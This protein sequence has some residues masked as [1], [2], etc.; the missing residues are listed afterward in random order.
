MTSNNEDSSWGGILAFFIVLLIL[1]AI[2]SNPSPPQPNTPSNP[3]T[4]Q[5]FAQSPSS[6]DI[7]AQLANSQNLLRA[8][9]NDVSRLEAQN[10]NIQEALD[11]VNNQL[12]LAQQQAREESK[13][14]SRE[15]WI[16]T[17]VGSL[18]GWLLGLIA[19]TR[20]ILTRLWNFIKR[21]FTSKSNREQEKNE[22][23]NQSK[24]AVHKQRVD[25]LIAGPQ[26]AI[27]MPENVTAIYSSWVKL[28]PK[29]GKLME[30]QM[31]TKGEGK[32]KWYYVCPNVQECQQ[33]FPIE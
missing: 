19:P 13:R 22:V 28:C 2:F 15:T 23:S 30:R 6:E 5:Q 16:A 12:S 29:C 3:Q 27:S 4:W 24:A 32:G 9:G 17:F 33:F 8:L 31:A 20:S 1:A 21:P 7:L 25:D 10:V 11:T 26:T 14:Q 18:V